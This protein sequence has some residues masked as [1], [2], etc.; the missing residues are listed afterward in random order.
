MA[1]GFRRK[2]RTKK[3]LL[4]SHQRCWLWG[5]HLVLETLKA[6]KWPIYELHL[7]LELKEEERDAAR[8]L[9]Q[10]LEIPFLIESNEALNKRCGTKEHQGYLAKMPPYPYDE[11]ASLESAWPACPMLLVLDGIQDPYNFGAILRSAEIFSADAVLIGS[12]NQS[13]ITSQV[14]RSSAGAVNYLKII[15][16]DDLPGILQGWKDRGVT[17][18]GASEKANVPLDRADFMKPLALA[19]GNE[20]IG[21]SPGVLAA[22]DVIVRIP[23][24]GRVGSLNAAV[25]AGILLYEMKRQRSLLSGR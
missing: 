11:L 5:R 10:E 17:I 8:K 25:S 6:R 15:R 4:G 16:E 9:A 7:A 18:I 13:G 22:C 12:R 2:R 1:E 21:I 24:S 14:A 20:G 3:P 19:I 23:Q